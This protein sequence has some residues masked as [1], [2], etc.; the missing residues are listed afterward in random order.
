MHFCC[1]EQLI[2]LLHS[3]QVSMLLFQIPLERGLGLWVNLLLE[4]YGC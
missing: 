2:I 3:Y 1:M 4:L